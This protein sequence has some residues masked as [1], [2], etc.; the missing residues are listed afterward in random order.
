LSKFTLSFSYIKRERQHSSFGRFTHNSSI[1]KITAY[2]L[3]NYLWESDTG[4][5]P[6]WIGMNGGDCLWRPRIQKSCS[7][8]DDGGGGDDDDDDDDVDDYDWLDS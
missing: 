7:A 6:H 1:R 4:G 5:Q 2:W 8:K 3:E